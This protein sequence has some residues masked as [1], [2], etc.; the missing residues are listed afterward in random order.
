MHMPPLFS[1]GIFL[2]NLG[3]QLYSTVQ[4]GVVTH[5]RDNALHSKMRLER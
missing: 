1:G 5:K 4:T 2:R 3:G